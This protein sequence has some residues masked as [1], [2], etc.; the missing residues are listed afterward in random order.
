MKQKLVLLLLAGALIMN[1]SGLQTDTETTVEAA[2]DSVKEETDSIS[3]VENSNPEEVINTKTS[4]DSIQEE[5][6]NTETGE[7]PV[8]ESPPMMEEDFSSE[9]EKREKDLEKPS[10][11]DSE[12]KMSEEDLEKQPFADSK[13]KVSEKDLEK[14][15]SADLEKKVSEEGL[16]KQPSA[17]SEKKV[18]IEKAENRNDVGENNGTEDTEDQEMNHAAA[19]DVEEQK[20]DTDTKDEDADQNIDHAAEEDVEIEKNDPDRKE[21][22]T[23]SELPSQSL[24][25][26]DSDKKPEEAKEDR[27]VGNRAESSI[28]ESNIIES[29]IIESNITESGKNEPQI[30]ESKSDES[31]ISELTST[32]PETGEMN[33]ADPEKS[34]EKDNMI[35]SVRSQEELKRKERESSTGEQLTAKQKEPPTAEQKEKPAAEQTK[36]RGAEQKDKPAEEQP[37]VTVPEIYEQI[38]TDKKEE[39]SGETEEQTTAVKVEETEVGTEEQ[40]KI[41]QVMNTEKLE[42]MLDSARIGISENK[43][44]EGKNKM[45]LRLEGAA[46]EAAKPVKVKIQLIRENGTVTGN[47]GGQ[48]NE[49]LV[50]REIVPNRV[51]GTTE[52]AGAGNRSTEEPWEMEI[53]SREDTGKILQEIPDND[54]YYRMAVTYED[55]EGNTASRDIPFKVNRF[56]S[57]YVYSQSCK[58]LQDSYVRSVERDLVISEYNPDRLVAKSLKVEIIRDGEPLEQVLYEVH[59]GEDDKQEDREQEDR[60]GWYRYDYIIS[61]KNFEKDGI[62][63]VSVSS[64]DEA[65]NKPDSMDYYQKPILFRVDSTNPEVNFIRLTERSMKVH[66][67]NILR[68]QAFDAIRLKNIRVLVDG[69]LQQEI[70]DI[71]DATNYQGTVRLTGLRKHKV[72]I[73]LT[74]MAGNSYRSEEQQVYGIP[75]WLYLVMGIICAGVIGVSSL[76]VIFRKSKR[77]RLRGPRVIKP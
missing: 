27:P 13:K 45:V 6:M 22:K 8:Q 12:K 29:N 50:T 32:K 39:K 52:A 42:S 63:Q 76:L 55:E 73:V 17:D 72:Q 7:N 19:E 1:G 58:D 59:S 23:K 11:A 3:F 46:F 4:M 38:N 20:K 14:P 43:D 57:V 77:L 35:Q 2:E 66:A 41:Q 33:R 34:K 61:R 31:K 37:E 18:S 30:T 10:S 69:K 53:L 25:E 36:E 65:G 74:D 51:S 26:G 15:S 48:E 21:K 60:K 5:T 47:A 16:E 24:E 70:S 68:Y 56:G 62:Y 71:P 28:T 49:I 75:V 64:A 44:S 54:G 9:N 40:K 67:E